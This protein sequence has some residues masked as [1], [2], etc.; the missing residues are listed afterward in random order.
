MTSEMTVTSGKRAK[1][2]FPKSSELVKAS[3]GI[4]ILCACHSD[5]NDSILYDHAK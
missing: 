3:I 4:A 1:D 5:T 2:Y